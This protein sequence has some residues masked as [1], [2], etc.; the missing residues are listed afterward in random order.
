MDSLLPTG[1]RT[2]CATAA[3]AAATP[4]WKPRDAAAR[5]W[6]W[7]ERCFAERAAFDIAS[8]VFR[9][10]SSPPT[11]PERAMWGRHG[12]LRV[13]ATHWRRARAVLPAWQP[14]SPSAASVVRWLLTGDEPCCRSQRGLTFAVDPALGRRDCSIQLRLVW[15]VGGAP[16][17]RRPPPLTWAPPPRLQ[18]CVHAL[19]C[20]L[21]HKGPGVRRQ[22]SGVS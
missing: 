4:F 11:G 18:K 9:L 13:R 14:A 2:C 21:G 6:R 8:D 10:L 15:F 19:L 20:A 5:A 16:A 1:G 17:A 12:A 3:W 22:A 7:A